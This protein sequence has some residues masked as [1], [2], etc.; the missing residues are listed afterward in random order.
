MD[1]DDL[2]LC[3]DELFTR[4]AEAR[5][6][7][8]RRFSHLLV[9]E[10]QDTNGVQY[11]IVKSLAGGHRNLCVV[12]DDDQ[13]IYGWR[14]ADVTHILQFQRDWPDAKVVRLEENYRSTPDILALANRLIRFNSQRHDKLLRPMLVAGERPQIWQCQ[15]E[16][17][18]A[19][20][21]VT[22]IR[23]RVAGG[24]AQPRDFAI[25]FRTN[26]QPRPFEAELRQAKLPYVMVGGMSFY[27]RREVRDILAYLKLLAQPGD[28]VSLRR[29][30]N[31]PARGIGA[32]A[33]NRWSTRRSR[34]ENR[35]EICLAKRT[36]CRRCNRRLP[37][38]CA[39]SSA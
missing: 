20:R 1:F 27:D 14:G 15:D 4:V 33:C 37:K 5:E 34:A 25:L 7:E 28:E 36:S 29:I 35:W 32:R 13:S 16:A 11:R 39:S 30:I 22:D 21:V 6:A 2:L 17:E 3:T 9:D 24:Q 26:E 12:G 38:R 18:E 8:V 23:Q 31:T 10:Y 19:K